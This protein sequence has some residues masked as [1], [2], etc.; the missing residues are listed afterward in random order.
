MLHGARVL[1]SSG[2]VHEEG[3]Q[4]VPGQQFFEAHVEVEGHRY[5]R[6]QEHHPKRAFDDVAANRAAHPVQDRPAPERVQQ[7]DG[8]QADGVGKRDR[9]HL[10]R[11]AAG[12]A[13][14]SHGGEDRA[15]A[16]SADE[17]E[18]GADREPRAEARAARART[19]PGQAGEGSLH[20][21]R[22][23]GDQQHQPERQQHHDRDGPGG[24][25]GQADAL[26]ELG[27][28][29]HRDRE[30]NGKADHDAERSSP[31]SDCS[32]RQQRGQHRQHAGGYRGPCAGDQREQQQQRH[33]SLE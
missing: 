22:R 26:D 28:G 9:H 7:E 20:A 4:V 30:R 11:G 23:L 6:C 15:G 27:Q 5:A 17:S 12:G 14:R 2:R 13:D 32:G 31:P 29:D 24:A 8:A 1:Q 3:R 18:R 19:E 25:A 16:G 33:R 10:H 21:R